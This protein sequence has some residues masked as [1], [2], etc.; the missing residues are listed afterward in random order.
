MLNQHLFIFMLI[1]NLQFLLSV[2]ID[3][4][5]SSGNIPRTWAALVSELS[6]LQGVLDKVKHEYKMAIAALDNSSTHATSSLLQQCLN[7][8]SD[9]C[10]QIQDAVMKISGGQ[11]HR[12]RSV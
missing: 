10:L 6:T 8:A 7:D 5:S 2:L 9:A 3:S 11:L 12:M 1:G 4:T